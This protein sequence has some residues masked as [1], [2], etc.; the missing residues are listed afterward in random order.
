[1]AIKRVQKVALPNNLGG[2]YE[3]YPAALEKTGLSTLDEMR[4]LPSVTKNTSVTKD[5]FIGIE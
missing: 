1:M 3:N 5:G 2:D 4:I